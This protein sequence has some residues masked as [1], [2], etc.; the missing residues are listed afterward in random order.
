MEFGK[1]HD[2]TDF[3]PRQVL[4]DLLCGETGVMD[5][6]LKV[7]STRMSIFHT[8]STI[9]FSLRLT[10]LA[11]QQFLADRTARPTQYDRLLA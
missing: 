9:I 1:G 4:T 2:T 8:Y 10:S 6:G 5:F 11:I 3:F 7:A